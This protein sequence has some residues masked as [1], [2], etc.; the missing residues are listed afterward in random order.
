[1]TFHVSILSNGLVR[2]Q[3]RRSLLVGLYQAVT[4]CYY[5]GDLMLDRDVVAKIMAGR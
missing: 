3:D 4:G 5:A 1:M 2:I